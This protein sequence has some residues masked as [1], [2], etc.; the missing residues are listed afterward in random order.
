MIQEDRETGGSKTEIQE[1]R[2]TGVRETVIRK[3]GMCKATLPNP[4]KN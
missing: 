1:D 3:I 4:Q 2:E